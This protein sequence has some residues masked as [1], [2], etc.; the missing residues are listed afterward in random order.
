MDRAL[1][2]G[3]PHLCIFGLMHR[4]RPPSQS[5]RFRFSRYALQ[6]TTMSNSLSL[7]GADRVEATPFTFDLP[8]LESLRP[9][10]STGQT[11]VTPL[12]PQGVVRMRLPVAETIALPRAEQIGIVP[13]SPKLPGSSPTEMISTVTSGAWSIRRSS[14]ESKF[15][16][17]GAPPESV[18]RSLIALLRPKIIPASTAR[19]ASIG[20]IARPESQTPTSRSTFKASAAPETSTITARRQR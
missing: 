4:A 9:A 2:P 13:T 3:G 14:Y 6:D 15:V 8:L 11:K 7:A 5:D 18:M 1:A 16:C 12:P 20:L 10:V 17:S 19:S